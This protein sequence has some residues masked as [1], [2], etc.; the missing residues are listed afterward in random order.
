M[1]GGG[2]GILHPGVQGGAGEDADK[3]QSAHQPGQEEPHIYSQ[4]GAPDVQGGQLHRSQAGPPGR[5]PKGPG[6]LARGDPPGVE[7]PQDHGHPQNE[8]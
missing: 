7:G 3:H 2:D 4:D 5:P 6:H 8:G 1:H